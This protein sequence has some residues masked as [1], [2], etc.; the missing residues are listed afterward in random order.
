MF[1]ERSVVTVY[2]FFRAIL[3]E[4]LVHEV[5]YLFIGGEIVYL[6]YP[7]LTRDGT[8]YSFCPQSHVLSVSFG[9][10][11]VQRVVQNGNHKTCEEYSAGFTDEGVVYGS[12]GHTCEN[13]DYTFDDEVESFHVFVV[14]MVNCFIYITKITDFYEISKSE[15]IKNVKKV[16]LDIS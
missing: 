10:G 13:D 7:D 9:D 8:G 15:V 5:L 14:L 2:M 1:D 11:D 6:I 3:V 12:E 4:E 16:D